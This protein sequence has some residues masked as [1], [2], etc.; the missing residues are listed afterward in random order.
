MIKGTAR[1]TGL[2]YLVMGLPAPITLMYM[3]RRFFVTG[4]ASATAANIASGELVYRFG[5][6]AGLVSSVGFV[7]LALSLYRLFRDVDRIQARLLLSLVLMA[8]VLG[9]VDL[10]LL[11]APLVFIHGAAAMPS[12]T[13]AQLDALALGFLRIR[14]AEVGIASSLWGLWLLPFGI[15]VM[16][17]RV[18]PAFIGMLLILG[19][20][21]YL[22][23][24]LTSIL[25]PEHLS[26]VS[27]IT[28]PLGAPG[29]L[30]IMLWLLIRGGRV[31]SP[32]PAPV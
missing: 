8:S 5:V 21:A 3:P 13:Q 19:G 9:L 17:S 15:L 27:R 24:S 22:A 23:G 18:I 31:P 30:A 25:Y 11:L 14:G 6:L 28:L 16:K 2:L 26:A 1:S 32:L 4:D 7:L 10:I 12:F 29:E 20:F